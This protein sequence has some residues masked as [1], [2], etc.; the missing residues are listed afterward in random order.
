MNT[1]ETLKNTQYKKMK[2]EIGLLA[3]IILV[4]GFNL[5]ARTRA[6]LI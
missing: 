4:L 2:Y 6:C 1:A 3:F 5:F